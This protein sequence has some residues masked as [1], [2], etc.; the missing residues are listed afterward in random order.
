MNLGTG[1]NYSA[2]GF[3]TV[4]IVSSQ[5]GFDQAGIQSPLTYV[6]NEIGPWH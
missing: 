4:N 6:L 5:G 3:V 2:V 1:L